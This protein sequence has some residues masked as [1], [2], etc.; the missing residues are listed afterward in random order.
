MELWQ[1]RKAT[2][3]GQNRPVEAVVAEIKERRH[4]EATKLHKN[5]AIGPSTIQIKGCHLGV[6]AAMEESRQ[7]KAVQ[8]A[9]AA[10]LSWHKAAELIAAQAETLQS[11]KAAKI[12]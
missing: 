3:L 12:L 4:T 10:E 8:A 9:Q 1:Y 5:A 2:K 11:G 6:P 7:V